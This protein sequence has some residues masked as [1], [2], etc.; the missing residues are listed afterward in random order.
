MEAVDAKTQ[1][2]PLS[3]GL[4]LRCQWARSSGARRCACRDDGSM[5]CEAVLWAARGA[6]ICACQWRAGDVGR[7]NAVMFDCQTLVR[8]VGCMH[9]P[10]TSVRTVGSVGLKVH[11]FLLR[12][13]PSDAQGL[14]ANLL[15]AV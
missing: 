14:K 4:N 8:C 1:H 12:T 2:G 13:G 11:I 15:C 9:E 3:F 6:G 10:L 5:A 7:L